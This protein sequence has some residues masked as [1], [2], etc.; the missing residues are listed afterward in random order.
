MIYK[1]KKFAE[2]ENVTIA[3]FGNGTIS[4]VN[5]SNENTKSLLLKS[6]EFSPIGSASGSENNSNDFK[7]ELVILFKNKESFDVF[8]EFVNNIKKE[9]ENS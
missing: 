4:V 2:V 5:G 1:N 6:K 9:Y 8:Y 7:P 3:E